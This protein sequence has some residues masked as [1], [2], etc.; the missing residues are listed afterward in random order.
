MLE[1]LKITTTTMF[2]V[3]EYAQL[4]ELFDQSLVLLRV[5]FSLEL[6]CFSSNME[7][8]L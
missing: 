2:V 4:T 6:E 7:D 1:L 3:M 8:E 5:F